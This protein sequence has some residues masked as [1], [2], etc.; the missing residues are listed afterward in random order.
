[1]PDTWGNRPGGSQEDRSGARSRHVLSQLVEPSRAE[2][3]CFDCTPCELEEKPGTFY[4][5]ETWAGQEALD[6]SIRLIRL[7]EAQ[8]AVG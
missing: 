8:A 7:R 2:P 3:G 6:I 5:R 1:M 4:V